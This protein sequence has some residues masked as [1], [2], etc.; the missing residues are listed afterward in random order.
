MRRLPVL[1]GLIPALF[2]A[3]SWAQEGPSSLE[4]YRALRFPATPANFDKGWEERVA[5]EFEIINGA[6]L[7]SLRT[8]LKDPDRFVRSMAARA[9]GI[10]GDQASTDSIGEMAKGDPEAAVRIRA[11]ES[12]GFLKARPDV[13]QAARKDPDGAVRWTAERVAG[14]LAEKTDFAALVREAYAVG[15][16]REEMG[17][18]TVGRPAP[19]FSA[20]KTDGTVFKLSEVLG[21]KPIALYFAAF[22]G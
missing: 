21:K 16:K 13:L 18:A 20:R 2:A 6:D 19:D 1:L 7:Q 14:Q 22:D 4:K 8:A 5:L 9:L 10:R 15:I 11:V 12:L 17:S 3:G